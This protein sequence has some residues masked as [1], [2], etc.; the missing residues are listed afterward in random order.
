[1]ARLCR[2]KKK[3]QNARWLRRNALLP[4]N[5]IIRRNATDVNN[6]HG[7]PPMCHHSIAACNFPV[8][9]IHAT[10]NM[11]AH[12]AN[13]PTC[14]HQHNATL[15]LI[16]HVSH[17]HSAFAS[18]PATRIRRA[19]AP[20]RSLYRSAGQLTPPPFDI[21][22]APLARPHPAHPPASSSQPRRPSAMLS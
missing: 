17:S 21:C 3:V 22:S 7:N 6:T 13:T 14:H 1:M 2:R 20:W 16:G 5:M 4:A 10:F 9:T 15:I 19:H 12:R 8:H 11:A 18:A